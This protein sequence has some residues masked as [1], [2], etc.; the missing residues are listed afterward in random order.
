MTVFVA[1][2]GKLWSFLFLAHLLIL[3]LFG[4]RHLPPWVQRGAE[5]FLRQRAS[6]SSKLV[7][8]SGQWSRDALFCYVVLEQMFCAGVRWTNCLS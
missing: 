8:S 5:R 1:D 3:V 6:E 7:P 2:R 4:Q